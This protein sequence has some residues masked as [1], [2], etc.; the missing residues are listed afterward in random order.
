ML[1]TQIGE[2][3]LYVGD[4]LYSDV[5][6]SKRTLGWRSAFIM[7]ELEEEMK[8]FVENAPL[9]QRISA[10]RKLRDEFGLLAEEI[11]RHQ[12]CSDPSVQEELKK[13]DEQERVLKAKLTEM[14][15]E[16][17]SAFHPIWGAMFHAGYQDS[18]F[19]FYVQNY[20][21]LYTSRSMTGQ[22]PWSSRANIAVSATLP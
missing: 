6:R 20:A 18:R 7:P 14:T 4:H 8:V 22:V 17:H 1:R 3:I 13:L 9:M 16:W 15:L 12:D 5:L 21:C 11:R 2:E 19:A 10:L